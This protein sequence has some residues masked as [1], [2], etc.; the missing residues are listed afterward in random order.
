MAKLVQMIFADGKWILLTELAI[1]AACSALPVL[2]AYFWQQ[3]LQRTDEQPSALLIFFLLLACSGGLM[4]A[5]G[6]F[7]EVFDTIFRHCVSKNMQRRVHQKAERLPMDDYEDAALNDLLTCAGE[8]FFYGDVLGFLMQGIYALQL[9]VSMVLTGCLVWSYHPILELPFVAML[10]VQALGLWTNHKKAELDLTLLPIRRRQQVYRAYLTKYENVKEVRTLGVHGLFCQKWRAAMREAMRCEEK[11]TAKINALRLIEELLKITAV[12]A[13]YLLCIFLA[14]QQTV[15][16]GPFGAL[17]LLM[18]QFQ[19][20]SA[21]FVRRVEELHA[22]AVQVQNGLA[23]FELP[24]EE[25]NQNFTQPL[26]AV[27]LEHVSYLYPE[28]KRSAVEDICL[29][30]KKNEIVAVVGSN[31]SGKTTLSGLICGLLVPTEGAVRFNEVP[32][33]EIVHEALFGRTS[34]VLQKFSRYALTVRENIFL[35]D[36]KKQGSDEE[37]QRLA[38]QMRVSFL[39]VGANGSVTLDTNLG[40]EY[41]GVELSGGQWQQLAI[42]RA[43]YKESELVI[44]DEPTAALDPL[45]EAELF[46]AFERMCKGKIGVIITHRLG[47]CTLADRIIHMEAGR[48][49]EMGSHQELMERGGRYAQVYRQQA[50]LYEEEC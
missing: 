35:G 41:G 15:G 36:I 42:L 29:Q 10:A 4:L 21:E 6:Y 48:I 12:I 11:T 47:M 50:R 3:I 13:A 8:K 23:Y 26:E 17:I 43:C 46:S 37:M 9:C 2:S 22:S 30:L 49:V 7:R 20:S 39:S 32:A 44:L 18:Q 25:R 16:I 40:V 5:N 24:E 34:A 19:G 31:G 28:A 27:T 1:V 45:K 14:E 38:S 33:A